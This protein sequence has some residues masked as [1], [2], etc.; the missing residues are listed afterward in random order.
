MFK[1]KKHRNL[2]VKKHPFWHVDLRQFSFIPNASIPWII[3]SIVGFYYLYEII[4]RVLPST[5]RLELI[6]QF[7][8]NAAQFGLFTSFYYLSYV[9]MQIPTGL[10]VDRYSIRKTL[11][12][13]CLFCILGLFLIHH[14]DQF[15]IAG[16]GRFI[17]GF[18]S[19]FAYVYTLK[20]AT[21]WLPK[22]HFGL[23]ICIADSLGMIG[24]IFADIIFVKVNAVSGIS[25]SANVLLIAGL[26]IAMLIFFVF[27]DKPGTKKSREL[28]KE[29]TKDVSHVFDK[30]GNIFRSKQIWLIGLVGCLFY[31]PA[32]VVG[33]VWG[34]PYLE[35]VYHFNQETAG[36]LI[37]SLFLGWVLAGPFLGAWSDRIRLRCMPMMLTIAINAMALSLIVVLPIIHILLPLW[38]LYVLFFIVGASAGTHPLVFALAKEN[39]P[40]R[41]AG[42]VVAVINTL[43]M[44]GGLLFQPLIGF[45]LDWS[46]G[47]L[48][49]K[50]A[51]LQYAPSDFSKAMLVIPVCLI[52]CLFVMSFIRETHAN[53]Q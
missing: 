32:S 20:V 31:L 19:A 13:A 35:S 2:H 26:V 23:A 49:A 47:T 53:E 21:I 5:M 28:N 43:T 50:T 37:S 45:I 48:G 16:I 33:D 42:T 7:Q 41:I 30:L 8:I 17:I 52:L 15:L 18:G 36:Y 27:R 12:T 4:L 24:A 40:D 22:K 25:H 1:P 39:F 6:N 34:I 46:H 38:L 29:D 44:L 3:W 9:I 51:V 10:I 11:L 14:T